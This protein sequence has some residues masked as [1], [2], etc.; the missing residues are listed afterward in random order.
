MTAIFI[1]LYVICGAYMLLNFKRDIHAFQLNSYRIS[2]YWRW[3]R[4]GNLM[5]AW[6]LTDV[7]LIFLLLTPFMWVG[8]IAVPI[9]LI[10]KSIMI[11]TAKYKKPLAFTKRVIRLYCCT[12]IIATALYAALTILIVRG[13]IPLH[14]N[15]YFNETDSLAPVVILLL[16]TTFSWAFV[17]LGAIVISPCEAAINRHYYNDA[18]RML[19]SMPDMKIIGITGSYGKTST[20][21]YLQRILSEKFEVLMTP[22]SFNTPMGVI[23]TVR[24][25]LKPYHEIFICEM[26]AK[27]TGDIKEIC[28]LVRPQM[29]IITAVGPMHLETF[30]S[31]EN[32]QRTKFE[33]ADALPADGLVVINNDFPYSASREVENVE[34]IRYG[35][36]NTENVSYTVDNIVCTPE[37][38]DFTVIGPN[39]LRLD[40]H[41]RLIG[42]SNLSNLTAAVIIALKL[43][44]SHEQ[45]RKAVEHIDQVEHRLS[46]KKT[47]A[48]VT[49]IDDAYNSN[50]VGSRMAVEALGKFKDGR[51]I[52]ITPGM[53][54]LGN[55]QY[56]L[57]KE[58]G[59]HIA[60]NV[61]I[62]IIVGEYN[63]KAISDG[64]KE[65]NVLNEDSIYYVSTFMESQ[66][67]LN[68]ELR[69]TKGDT[70]LYENDLPD[71][72]K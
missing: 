61:D 53:I 31:I 72:F 63:R 59:K 30:K 15:A 50:P 49:I 57:N 44:V 40:L 38:T 64:I 25:M 18:A 51:R 10:V 65:S 48:G 56:E 16:M 71:T 43:G 47:P 55:R 39:N 28:D 7:A 17:M 13:T 34:A 14:L 36:S 70:V 54:E 68:S 4:H 29:G 9:T 26:G 42:E 3:L 35:I 20:K 27:Q 5:P 1:T 37:G 11:L 66:Q 46:M 23:R 60:R 41:T 67:L 12:G 69:M 52:I 24:E 19:R 22:G 21:H 45:I 2:R 62:A 8:L 6:R 33:L 58:F 32:V